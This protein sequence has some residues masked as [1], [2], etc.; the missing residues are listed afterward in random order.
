MPRL[1]LIHVHFIAALTL[2]EKHT[3]RCCLLSYVVHLPVTSVTSTILL[4]ALFSDI[5]YSPLR[6]KDQVIKSTAE[7]VTEFK[8]LLKCLTKYV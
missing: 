3:I 2:S 4:N 5:L 8:Y 6:V 1:Y 7:E